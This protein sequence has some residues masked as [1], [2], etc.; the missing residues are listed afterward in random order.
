MSGMMCQLGD[1]IETDY[2]IKGRVIGWT[3]RPTYTIIQD[4]GTR[5]TVLDTAI[6]KFIPFPELPTEPGLYIGDGY[7]PSPS[8]RRIVELLNSPREW[9]TH[10]DS[11]FIPDW[12]IRGLK[13][14]HR[15][16][17]IFNEPLTGEVVSD[18]D[19]AD[20]NDVAAAS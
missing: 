4:D 7:A 5:V 19:P 16:I 2:G 14:L 18:L 15:L 20:P 8:G 1:F 12:E 11:Q 9:F 13:N 3:D 6:T 10:D 17:E